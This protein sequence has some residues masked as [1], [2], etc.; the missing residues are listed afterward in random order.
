MTID[1]KA[2]SP[3]LL[4]LAAVIPTLLTAQQSADAPPP[5]D[6]RV[7]FRVDDTRFVVTTMGE[8]GAVALTQREVHALT[9]PR[10]TAVAQYLGTIFEMPSDRVSEI[11][12]RPV[13]PIGQRWMLDA[14]RAGTFA[15][16][17]ERY[18][19]AEVECDERW[20]VMLTAS[21]DAA[22]RLASVREKYF[23]AR[24]AG[25][26]DASTAVASVGPVA[27]TLT[28][29][30]RSQLESLLRA[31]ATSM[32]STA[33]VDYDVQAF[34]LT[35]DGDPRLFVRAEVRAGGRIDSLLG[36]WVRLRATGDLEIE[37]I[38][39]RA[40]AL[41]R[42]REMRHVVVGREYVGRILNVV[43]TNHDGWGEV[44][45]VRDGYESRTIEVLEYPHSPADPPR[46]VASWATGC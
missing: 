1:Q 24:V 44:F 6:W 15:L 12:P 19:I 23:V 34:R 27:V 18:V 4:L 17:V 28:P 41:P 14:G 46:V 3:A 29:A 33:R 42:L 38:D 22:P 21:P 35:P 45:V 40:A 10:H 20:G 16:T 36:A 26:G 25:A 9:T 31:R 39:D 8:E 7:A 32:P 30:Q 43:D 37:R 2:S 5:T 11:V 13:P